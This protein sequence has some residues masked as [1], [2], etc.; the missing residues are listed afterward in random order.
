LDSPNCL[1]ILRIEVRAFLSFLIW[2]TWFPVG[3]HAY[4]LDAEH[5][6]A[7]FEKYAEKMGFDPIVPAN[8]EK[9]T[10]ADVIAAQVE[11]LKFPGR[12]FV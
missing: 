3:G 6:R 12:K 10:A 9:I 7:Y 4:W 8:W 5:R 1:S 11:Y 2:F